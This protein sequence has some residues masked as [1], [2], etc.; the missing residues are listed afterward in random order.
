MSTRFN[1]NGLPTEVQSDPSTPLLDVLRTE[2]RLTG[3]KQGCDHEG[4]CG[5]CTVLID[6]EPVQSC[7]TLLGAVADRHVLTIEGLK[8]FEKL[9]PLQQAFIQTG[10]VQCGYCTPGMLMAAKA[11]LIREPKPNRQQIIEALD[12]NLCRCTGYTRIIDAVEFAAGMTP[13]KTP[14]EMTA[15]E[16]YL[17]M[18]SEG[19]VTGQ[20]P[21][22]E[23]IVLPDMLHMKVLRSP[24]HHARLDNIDTSSVSAMP[25]IRRVISWKDIPGINGF[26]EYSLEEPVLTPESDTLRMKGAPIALVIADTEDQAQAGCKAIKIKIDP[27]PFTFDPE[28]ALKPGA[29]LI[30]GNNNELSSFVITQGD[31]ETS[32]KASKNVI[33]ATYETA[34]LEHSALERESAFGFIDEKGRVTVSGATHQPHN[35]QRYVSEMLGIPLENVRV[36]TPPIGGSFGGKQDP[37]PMMAVA[38]G[39]YLLRKPIRLVYSRLESFDASPKRHPYKVHLK[40]GSRA[41]GKLTGLSASI[42]CNTGGYDSSGRYITNYAVTAIGGAYR[43]QAV[44]LLARSIYTNGPKAGQYRGFGTA[45]SNF[46]LECALDEIIEKLDLDPVEFRI[47]N[48][49]RP[50]ENTFLGYPL[51]ETLGYKEVLEQIRPYHKLFS[52]EAKKFNADHDPDKVRRGVGLAGMWYRFGKAGTLKIE[53]QAALSSEGHYIVYCSAPDYGQGTTTAMNQIAAEALGV[54]R[55]WVNVVNADTGQV[56]DSNIQGASRAV[57]FVGGAVTKAVQ[58]L[59]DSI[60]SVAAEMLDVPGKDLELKSD[61]VIVTAQPNRFVSTMDIAHEFDLMGKSRRVTGIFDVSPNLGDQR[62]EYL[63]IFIT[64]AHLADLTVDMETGMVQVV[65]VVAAHD[66]G[67]AVNPV[68]SSGQIEGAVLMGLGAT[69]QEEYLPGLTT[70]FSHYHLPTIGSTPEIKTILVEVPSKYGPMGAKGLGEAAMLP[71]TPA[72]I[73]AISRSIHERIRSIP[74]TPEQI[75]SAIQ[76]R[77]S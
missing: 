62:P 47:K 54:S 38:L 65:R 35:Q 23:D 70:G 6:N 26:P 33:D 12:G 52:E 46:A 15:G 42:L 51:I 60:F 59:K 19:K 48:C 49:I 2:L 74:A 66:V 27:L 25:G 31:L 9:D 43:W 30:A 55:N 24:L 5:A 50:G 73:N 29:T 16:D 64:G 39:V 61:R 13:E 45:Q 71:T 72:I 75:L 11:L 32:L 22:V 7:L 44:N 3:T 53:A 67:K 56:P 4:E 37:W 8:Q 36:I 40:L 14:H 17:R 1:L 18:D 58:V 76:R 10:A 68:D 41:D 63:P 77:R 21:Y 28:E 34:F 20:T 69:L 57:Y